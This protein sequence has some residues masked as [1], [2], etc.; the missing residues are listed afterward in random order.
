MIKELLDYVSKIENVEEKINIINDIKKWLH[1]I[2]PFKNEPV[3][4]VLWIKN[5]WVTSN[6]Y[7]PNKVAPPEM[8]LLEVSIMNDWYTQPIVWRETNK[9]WESVF[10][11]IDWFHRHRVW[12][13]SKVVNNRVIWYLPI[14]NIRKDQE[15]K[16]NRIASTIRHNRARGKHQI[17]A[18]SE[19]VIELKNRNWK[20]E[21]I[22]KELWMDE[23]EV[24]RLLQIS[25]LQE[26]FSSDDFSKAR[27]SDD[28][29]DWFAWLDDTLDDE[30]IKWVRVVNV[31]DPDRIFHTYD[32]REC[33]KNWFYKQ[34]VE[35]KTKNQLE[36][37]FS[38]FFKQEWLFEKVGNS[39]IDEWVFSCEH[40]LTNKCMNRI[41]WIWQACVCY[42]THIP[43]KYSSW[44]FLLDRETQQK[45]N[46]I[47][48]DIINKRMVK[49]GRQEITMKEAMWWVDRQVNIY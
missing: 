36:I 17:D 16:N 6:D 43:N 26:M 45:N 7:N 4:C 35:W 38:D 41:A 39:V 25:W 20:N 2:S 47:A 48:L 11:I 40:Y 28:D 9:D 19:I 23:D 27:V 30:F 5:T 32:K 3:D 8:E 24:L 33:Y 31:D 18:M 13:E 14:V 34:N 15:D 29:V 46:L 12:K 37:E 49:N 1:E 10:E 42:S 21:R 22:A 44:W